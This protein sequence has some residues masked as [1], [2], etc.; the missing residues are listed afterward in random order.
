MVYTHRHKSPATVHEESTSPLA[1]LGP[2]TQGPYR[3]P[4]AE[5]RALRRRQ[6]AHVSL[7][8]TKKSKTPPHKI[9]TY[10]QPSICL[11]AAAVREVGLR[12]RRARQDRVVCTKVSPCA[13]KL[14]DVDNDVSTVEQGHER[15]W[16]VWLAVLSPYRLRR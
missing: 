6:K 13:V 9:S 1:R 14:H 3:C 15:S 16:Q 11:S 10:N 2:G 8:S 12:A 5:L 7:E 4:T